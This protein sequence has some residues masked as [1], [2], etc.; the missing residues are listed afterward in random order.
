M[1]GGETGIGRPSSKQP[2]PAAKPDGE[3]KEAGKSGDHATQNTNG[4]D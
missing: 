1:Y 4:R 3:R 2:E